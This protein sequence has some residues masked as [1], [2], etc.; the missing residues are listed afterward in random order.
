MPSSDTVPALPHPH[1]WPRAWTVAAALAALPLLALLWLLLFGWNWARGPLQDLVQRDTGRVLLIEGDLRLDL[2]WPAPRLHA[3]RVRFAN[4]PWA[5]VPQM[6]VADAVAITLDLPELLR[7]RITFPEVRLTRPLIA[8]EQGPGGRKTWL[9][10]RAQTDEARVI[11]IGRLLLDQGTLTYTDPTRATALQ[12]A[13]DTRTPAADAEHGLVFQAAGQY[14]GLP[15]SATGSGG[16][17][18][19][20]HDGEVPY[21]VDV[22]ARIGTTQVTARGTVTRLLELSALDLQLTLQGDSA[23]SLFPLIGVALPRTPA[24][25]TAGRL[26]HADQLWHYERFSGQ[27]G[28]SALSGTL[29]FETGG[30][31]VRVTGALASPRLDLADLGPAVGVKDAPDTTAPKRLLPELPF[32]T[33][34]WASLDADVTLQA[35]SLLNAAA[36][37]LDELNVRLQLQDRRMTLDPL[38]FRLAG[39]QM[40]AQVTLDGRSAPLRGQA[41]VQ[42]RGLQLARLFPPTDQQRASIGRVDGDLQLS[43]QGASVGRM[44]A[45]ADG[46]VSLVA[47]D[48]QISRL[49]VEQMGLHLLEIL[50]LSLTGDQTVQLHCAVADFSVATGVMQARAL[51]LDTAVNTVVGRGS[52]DLAQERLDLTLQPRTKVTSL[53][54][55]RSPIHVTGRFDAPQVSIDTGRLAAR[56]AGALL[57]GLVNPLLALVPLLETA[58]DTPDNACRRLLQDVQAAQTPRPAGKP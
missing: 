9:L 8:L 2:A 31:R 24:Y 14:L 51:V 10:D 29:Q 44:L 12:I 3:E 23:A 48:G 50:Q 56:S 25:R 19:G 54:A 42:L 26:R 36:L 53:V 47:R 7:G 40:K 41:T 6:V 28:A 33:A 45:T 15:L 21:P 46:R 22:K 34:R 16:A 27:V 32:D 52:V 38:V 55:L 39:G 58:G 49:L 13:L 18:M 4:P 1:R 17:V 37:P 35:H 43:G 11:P 20:L 30:P 5:A 57:L